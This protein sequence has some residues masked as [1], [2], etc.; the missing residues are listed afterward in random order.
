[1]SYGQSGFIG[2]GKEAIWGTPVAAS[3]YIEAMSENLTL[4]I[5]RFDVKNIVGRLAEPDDMAGAQRYPVDI[6]FPVHAIGIGH[7]LRSVFGQ[8]SGSVVLSGFLWQTDFNFATAD[9]VAA[10][11][12]PPY[13]FEVF[14]D[15]TSSHRYGGAVVNA[16]KLSMAPNQDL[17]C[18][19]SIISKTSSIIAKSSASFPGSPV[20]PF[21]FDT[22]SLGIA[23]AGSSLIQAL[24]IDLDNQLEGALALAN[25][26]EI[27][28]IRRRG[29]QLAKLS[30]TIA[31]DDMTEYNNF[32]NQT[33]QR[34]TASLFRAQSFQ[35]TLDMPRVVY[36]AFPLGLSDRGQLLVNFEGKCRYHTGSLTA[37]KVSLTTVKSN[38]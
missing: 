12:V 38:Y 4:I 19:A 8:T 21:A 30:G 31:F 37:I 13:T 1:M 24:T 27:S 28:R 22:V 35:L 34:F 7:F 36:T 9:F 32:V 26:T 33:E 16:L 14:R 5:D 20:T 25:T 11:A 3:D 2:I 6:V 15:V 18:T 10:C 29:P 17:R 23:G